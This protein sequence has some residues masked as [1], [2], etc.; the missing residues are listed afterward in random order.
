MGD[1]GWGCRRARR[2]E[3]EVM[4]EEILQE[5]LWTEALPLS[6]ECTG[7]ARLLW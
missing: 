2:N 4:Q 6:A 3:G 5:A 7:R 1:G